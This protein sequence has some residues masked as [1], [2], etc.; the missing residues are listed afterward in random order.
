MVNIREKSLI[1]V[2]MVNSAKNE[3][4]C[5]WKNPYVPETIGTIIELQTTREKVM[6]SARYKLEGLRVVFPTRRA[7]DID[8]EYGPFVVPKDRLG[9]IHLM[10]SP[11]DD[12]PTDVN[13]I[14]VVLN[15]VKRQ[16]R[17]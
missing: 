14:R 1:D 11:I 10:V 13:N 5:E 17:S 2:Y 4:I 15:A 8:D 9:E 3:F 7:N 6:T 16:A 12:S